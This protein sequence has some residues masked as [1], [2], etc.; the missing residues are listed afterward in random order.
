MHF[1]QRM[2]NNRCWRWESY[3]IHKYQ[4]RNCWLLKKVERIVTIVFQII[5]VLFRIATSWE[6]LSKFRYW[7]SKLRVIENFYYYFAIWF[8]I[9]RHSV[10]CDLQLRQT[11]WGSW[12]TVRS[13]LLTEQKLH[14]FNVECKSHSLIS[15]S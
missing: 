12:V 11:F 4:M 13:I 10:S 3:E 14:P 15:F 5:N 8:K 6:F 2:H 9:K 7:N 1:V